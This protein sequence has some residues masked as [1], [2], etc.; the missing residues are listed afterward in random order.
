MKKKLII[1]FI[2]C[3]VASGLF[4]G[5]PD[6]LQAEEVFITIGGGDFPEFISPPDW[7]LQK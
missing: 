7:P 3:F 5:L 4:G 1:T 6:D 2:A